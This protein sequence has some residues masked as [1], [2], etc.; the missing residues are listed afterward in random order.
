MADTVL[1]EWPNVLEKFGSPCVLGLSN[2]MP[3]TAEKS[4]CGR[5]NCPGPFF[6]KIRHFKDISHQLWLVHFMT[7]CSC[8]H[9]CSKMA[10]F[11]AWVAGALDS[12]VIKTY[13]VRVL[14]L[15]LTSCILV[16]VVHS[17][18]IIQNVFRSCLTESVASRT[19]G[20][21]ALCSPVGHQANAPLQL[22]LHAVSIRQVRLPLLCLPTSVMLLFKKDESL[23]NVLCLSKVRWSC[24]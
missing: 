5:S 10:T 24:Y 17:K 9:R 23:S 12:L 21:P 15:F 13:P 2:G 4:Q 7:L 8:K 1:K 11:V 6:L 22:L 18:T 20:V 16:P 19:S 14:M 3:K